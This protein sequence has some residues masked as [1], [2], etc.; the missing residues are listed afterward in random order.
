MKLGRISAIAAAVILTLAAC[1]AEPSKLNVWFANDSSDFDLVGLY[2]KDAKALWSSS[3]IPA[4]KSLAVG[5][6]MEFVIPLEKGSSRHYAVEVQDGLETVRLTLNPL[7]GPLS[8]LH[9][10]NPTR[11]VSITVRRGVDGDQKPYVSF[12]SGA[13]YLLDE[14]A[15]FTKALW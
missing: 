8:I 4:G 12:E 1:T 13:D 10:S 15:T 14:Q 3:F 9:W 6:Y 11:Y 7:D 5:Q 2:V